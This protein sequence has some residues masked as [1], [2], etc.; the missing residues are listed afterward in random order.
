MKD[1][2][3]TGTIKVLIA[4][5]HAIVR[6]GLASLLGAKSDI[7]VVGEAN[8]GEVAVRKAV[9]LMPDVVVMDLMMPKMDGVAATRA[10]H[11]RLPSAKVLLLT[12][13]GTSDRLVRSLEAGASG[14]IMKS[15]TNSALIGAA[16]RS[17]AA[18]IAIKKHMLKL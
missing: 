6:M 15:T 9:K 11:E 5:D 10:L 3:S 12:T 7:E 13:F 1:V 2:K 8:N 18:S 4:D 14:A 16:N 17:E